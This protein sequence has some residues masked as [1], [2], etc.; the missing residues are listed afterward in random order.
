MMDRL[1]QIVL[2]LFVDFAG[3]AE[4]KGED[5]PSLL[6]SISH[7]ACFPHPYP[8]SLIIIRD[9]SLQSRSLGQLSASEWLR[10]LP[11]PPRSIQPS[12]T[13]GEGARRPPTI[14]MNPMH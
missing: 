14:V 6:I 1:A 11:V 13:T 12:P 8:C 7:F 9:A 3:N 10:L 4:K 2:A 5:E